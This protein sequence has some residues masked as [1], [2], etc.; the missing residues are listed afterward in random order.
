MSRVDEI[1]AN[2]INKIKAKG[3]HKIKSSSDIAELVF[4]TWNRNEIDDMNL[5]KLFF[6]KLERIKRVSEEIK[7]AKYGIR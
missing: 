2:Y 5:L 4:E 1:Q 3:S 6:T 7:L